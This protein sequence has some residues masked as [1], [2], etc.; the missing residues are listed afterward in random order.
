MFLSGAAS[1]AAASA[2]AACHAPLST[3][4]RERLSQAPPPPPPPPAGRRKEANCCR[5]RSSRRGCP[6]PTGTGLGTDEA[7]VASAI[8]TKRLG[9]GPRA[10]WTAISR[11]KISADSSRRRRPRRPPVNNAGSL[12]RLHST[13]LHSLRFHSLSNKDDKHRRRRRRPGLE[14]KTFGRRRSCPR[15]QPR[16]LYRP[17]RGEGE[18]RPDPK[19]SRLNLPQDC[20]TSPR[21][22]A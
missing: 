3:R 15:F 1:T 20:R 10:S 19:R 17:V 16:D 18:P 4:R 5:R 6:R 8:Q 22:G 11:I 13:P 9:T 2:S 7:T 14:R 12:A 21:P